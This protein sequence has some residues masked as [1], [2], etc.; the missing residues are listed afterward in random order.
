MANL[1][2]LGATGLVGRRVVD[3]ALADRRVTRVIAPT[4]RPIEVHAKLLNPVV[5]LGQGLPEADW[6]GVD[7]VIC[8][9]GTTRKIAG[10]DA[11]FRRVDLEIPLS[12]AWKTREA[13]A[14]C[15][16]LTSSIGANAGSRLLYPRT[17]GELEQALDT[18][19]FASLTILR[20]NVLGGD[21]SEFRLGERMALAVLGIAHVF[22][23][24]RLRVSPADV[25]AKVLLEAALA[26]PPGWHLI[27][28]DQLSG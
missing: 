1:L 24:R 20:P 27:E 14:G 28:A 26:A 22:L 9:I 6:W 3:L 2:V 15:F 8:A 21:R 11:A 10:S 16:V 4:R 19:G 25:V 13:G 23:P 17:K 7:A 18:L 12:V 5:D